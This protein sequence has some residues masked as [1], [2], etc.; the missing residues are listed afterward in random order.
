MERRG[1]NLEGKAA[2]HEH[3]ADDEDRRQVLAGKRKRDA[4]EIGCAGDAIDKRGAIKQQARR[5]RAEKELFQPRLGRAERARAHR[6]DDIE[7]QRL[8]LDTH[9]ER[10]Q[11][12]GR[13]HQHHADKR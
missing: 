9:I 6:R 3:H 2:D 10:H 13:D 1:G 11:V 7:R 8:Q 12:V 4:V 5:Q